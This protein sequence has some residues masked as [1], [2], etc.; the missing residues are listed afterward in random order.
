MNIRSFLPGLWQPS[1]GASDPF[2]ALRQEVDRAFESFGR[3]LPTVNWPQDVAAPKIN[4][5]QNDKVLEISAELPGVDI[6]DVELLV[7]RGMLTIRGEK[8]QEKEDNSAQRHVYECSYGAFSRT[9]PLPFEASPESVAAA[10]KNGVLTISIPV[11]AE[12]QPKAKRVEI[13]PS[14]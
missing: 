14:V 6:K 3:S 4:M 7:D 11:P 13:K 12:A 2:M 8:K 1:N 10:F 5:M 9:I